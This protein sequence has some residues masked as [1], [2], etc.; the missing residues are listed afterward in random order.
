M[1]SEKLAARVMAHEI[2]LKSILAAVPR[3]YVHLIASEASGHFAHY[4]QGA[5]SRD[6][7]TQHKVVEARQIAGQLLG[8]SID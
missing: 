3:A 2:L 7:D 1:S 4:Q 8:K 5:A 6:E